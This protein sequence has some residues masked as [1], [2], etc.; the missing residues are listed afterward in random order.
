MVLQIGDLEHFPDGMRQFKRGVHDGIVLDDLRDMYFLVRH[1][2]KLQGK[3][4]VVA[5]FASTPSGSYAYCT[6]LWRVPV[7]ITANFTT[8]NLDLLKDNTPRTVSSWSARPRRRSGHGL[9]EA[10]HG[11]QHRRSRPPALRGASAPARP[12]VRPTPGKACERR[13]GRV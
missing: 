1:Q 10:A 9:P 12:P 6:W 7:V 11:A 5:E 4:D 2:E 13:D 3:V 8:R